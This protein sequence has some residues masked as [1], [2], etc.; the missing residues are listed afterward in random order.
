MYIY[1]KNLNELNEASLHEAGGKGAN[2]GELIRAGLPVP[3]GFVV[4]T[5]AYRTLLR[6]S[7]LYELIS[8][9]LAQLASIEISTISEASRDIRSWIEKAP[10]PIEVRQ[11][12]IE[13][14]SSLT[15]KVPGGE[16]LYVAVRSSSTAEDLPNA[17]FAGQYN[18]FLGVSGNEAI[19][20][21]IR[22]CWLSLWTPQAITYRLSMGFDHRN[23]DL[24]VVVQTMIDAETAG[25]MFTVNPVN[26]SKNELLISAGYGLGEAVVSGMIT[27]DTYIL[28]KSGILKQKILGKKDKKIIMGN[29]GTLTKIVSDA[30]QNQ[31]CLGENELKQLTDLADLVEKHYK[32]PQDI[33]WASYHGKIYLL[34]ARPITTIKSADDSLDILSPSDKII[35]QY[36][37]PSFMLKMTME[38]LSEPM[39]PLDFACME[40]RFKGFTPTDLSIRLVERESGCVAIDLS[41]ILKKDLDSILENKSQ[42]KEPLTDRMG[43]WKTLLEEMNLCLEKMEYEIIS[44]NSAKKIIELLNNAVDDF[45]EYFK[46]RSYIIGG[47]GEGYE[48][49]LEQWLKNAV[50]DEN[51]QEIKERLLKALPFKTAIQNAALVKLAKA[52][53]NGKTDKAFA[54]EFTGF[55]QEYGDRPT[56]GV[57][58]MLSTPT[59][60]ERPEIIHGMIDSLLKENVWVNIEQE[61]EKQKVDYNEAVKAMGRI[62]AGP[63][64]QKFS[65]IL[66]AARNEII[67]R[68]DSSFMLERFTSCLR[69]IAMKLGDILSNEQIIKDKEDVFYLFLSELNSLADGQP[70]I[71]EKIDKRKS[72]FDKV[73][74]AHKKGIHWMIAT[75]SVQK[76]K[77]SEQ[78]S[79]AKQDEINTLRGLPVSSGEYVG[80]VCIVRDPSD[81]NKLKR[82]DILV[83]PYTSPVWTPL[84][85]VAAALVTE[86][87]SPISHAAIIAREYGIPAVVAIENATH[88]LQD[89]QKIRVD[90]SKGSVTILEDE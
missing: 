76:V 29:N 10:M 40:Q 11:E 53:L 66:E 69:K 19:L 30:R 16:N 5:D 9:R 20:E 34:Q 67:I 62:T 7:G 58:S 61:F 51:S 8:E 74:N 3:S 90:G 59:W 56:Y 45:G 75:G 50:G 1:T 22:K 4:T 23:A 26:G 44:S 87:G 65:Q 46:K 35:Y 84:F 55:L 41:S 79:P 68:E 12:V 70:V 39:K 77:N 49:Q 57:T 17:S 25:V 80:T 13:K 27:P 63:E 86:I 42:A 15:E 64:Y 78:D 36:E 72:A 82:G 33:E 32:K 73:Y 6:T 38:R 31:Y 71:N 14:V 89:G 54:S 18:T 88:I 85:K 37:K 47:P 43:F 2:L 52:A 28:T 21:Q 24:A 48:Y 83:S 81:F 60:R